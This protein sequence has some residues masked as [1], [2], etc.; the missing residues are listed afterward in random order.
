VFVLFVF[1]IGLVAQHNRNNSSDKK[2]PEMKENVQR[3]SDFHIGELK[4]KPYKFPVLPGMNA[5]SDAE[6][7]NDMIKATNIPEDVLKKM[8][9]DDLLATIMDYPQT[10]NFMAYNSYFSGLKAFT[11]SPLYQEF[12]RRSDATKKTVDFYLTLDPNVPKEDERAGPYSKEV[13]YS[14]T[15]DFLGAFLPQPELLNNLT[16]EQS[17][18][19]LKRVLEN[20]NK[21]DIRPDVYGFND[22]TINAFLAGKILIHENTND[23]PTD[24]EMEFFLKEGYMS[25]SEKTTSSIF[26]ATQQFLLTIK[27]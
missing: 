7:L 27:K 17:I 21:M 26:T 22:K 4:G 20:Q 25:I 8:S 5:W 11:D 16:H 14:W 18:L 13:F 12:Y 1:T 15:L 10:Y 9:T 3:F 2:E 19:V 23:L 24:P 6:S